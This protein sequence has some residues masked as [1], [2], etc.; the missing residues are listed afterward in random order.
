MTTHHYTLSEEIDKDTRNRRLQER[1]ERYNKDRIP[2][3]A[4]SGNISSEKKHKKRQRRANNYNYNEI[5]KKEVYSQRDYFMERLG[6]CKSQVDIKRGTCHSSKNDHFLK[7]TYTSLVEFKQSVQCDIRPDSS[8]DIVGYF[9]KELQESPKD[10]VQSLLFQARSA[11]HSSVVMKNHPNQDN[12]YSFVFDIFSQFNKQLLFDKSSSRFYLASYVRFCV[13]DD[14]M[15]A[16]C[17]PTGYFNE[18]DE[19]V[20]YQTQVPLHSLTDAELIELL[21]PFYPNIH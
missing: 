21:E 12:H 20:D 13:G 19:L 16:S 14:N 9:L 10:F 2:R 7:K 17:H 3:R 1:T 8:T 4:N 11:F 18:F 15:L 6:D 5:T